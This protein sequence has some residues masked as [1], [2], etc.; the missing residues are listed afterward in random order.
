MTGG[1]P[2]LPTKAYSYARAHYRDNVGIFF[3]GRC[4]FTKSRKRDNF[5]GICPRN[6]GKW[7]NFACIYLFRVSIWSKHRVGPWSRLP[8]PTHALDVMKNMMCINV[9]DITYIQKRYVILSA[10]SAE[11]GVFCGPKSAKR[12][13]FSNLGASMYALVGGGET[14]GPSQSKYVILP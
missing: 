10:I 2:P 8:L 5:S 1:F 14:R 11:K 4:E 6:F 9:L 13:W 12:G 7:Q 3:N